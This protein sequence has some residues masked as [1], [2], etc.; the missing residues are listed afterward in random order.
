MLGIDAKTHRIDY[1][2][3]KS[4]VKSG[5]THIL[6]VEISMIPSWMWNI[7]SHIKQQQGFIFIGVGDWMQLPP[8][9]EEDIELYQTWVVKYIFDAIWYELTKIFR[10]GD[11]QLLQ[12]AHK[13]RM[14]RT[15]DYT[16]Y[17]NK[18]HGLALCHTNDMVNTINK[19]WNEFHAKTKD[20]QRC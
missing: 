8:V 5:V 13:A 15:I 12:D 16:R 19:K 2:L 10:F 4:Y 3:I 20:K 6:I 9:G 17:G 18:G 14:G 1:K 11:C 7:L